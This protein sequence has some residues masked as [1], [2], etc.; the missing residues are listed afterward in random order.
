MH[1][2]EERKR[3]KNLEPKFQQVQRSIQSHTNVDRSPRI[4]KTRDQLVH[5]DRPYRL[6]L[7]CVTSARLHHQEDSGFR[8]QLTDEQRKRKREEENSPQK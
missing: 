7:T 5:Y 1:E 2:D 6:R 4:P 8:I 3:R